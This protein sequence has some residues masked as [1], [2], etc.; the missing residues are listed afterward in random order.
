MWDTQLDD[1]ARGLYEDVCQ[2]YAQRARPTVL[3][4]RIERGAMNNKAPLLDRMRKEYEIRRVRGVYFPLARQGD[5]WLNATDNNGDR[6]FMMFDTSSQLK[7]ALRSV[8]SNGFTAITSGRKVDN[9]SDAGM[10]SGFVLDVMNTISDNVGDAVVADAMRDEVYQ[11]FLKT[12]PDMSM[13]KALIH[14]K[15]VAGYSNDVIRG[16]AIR[17]QHMAHQISGCVSLTSCRR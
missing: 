3:V 15:K 8:N 10:N 5:Y 9:E 12:M 14:R 11:L 13:R 2:H 4:E 6:V 1:A 7:Q 16:L 17:S